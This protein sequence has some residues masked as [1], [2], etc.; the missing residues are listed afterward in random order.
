MQ[1]KATEP[2]SFPLS[3]SQQRLWFLDQLESKNP[4][5]NIPAA[6]RLK[7][8]LDVSVLEET[9]NQIQRRH[10]VLQTKFE[11][12]DGKPVQE[13]DL[14]KWAAWMETG[15]RIVRQH[16]FY[17]YP[18][19]LVSTVFLGLDHSFHLEGLPIL[20]ETMVFGGP[21]NSY[22]RRYSSLGEALKGHQEALVAA[23]FSPLLWWKK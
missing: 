8:R 2:K 4:T 3:Y 16:S 6:F 1:N 21:M 9:I 13:P 23:W 15:N 18:F 12:V 19:R 11:T 20:W 5:Y 22:Q 10:K 7:G 17:G 14:L